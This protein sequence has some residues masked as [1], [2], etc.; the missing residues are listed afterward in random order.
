MKVTQ[1]PDRI[2]TIDHQKYLYFGGTSYLGLPN[3]KKFK[4]LLIKNILKWGTT[5]GSSRNANIQLTAYDDGEQFLANFI[6]SE[7][8]LTV[9]SGMLA[10]K[11]II[12]ILTPSTDCFFHFPN[13]HTALQAPNSL[14][15]FIEGKI[16][17]RLLNGTKE[18]ITILTDA[19]PS[20]LIKANDLSVLE[21]ISKTKIITLVLDESHSLGILGTHGCGIFSSIKYPTIQRKIMFSSLG[22]S[23]GLT[24]GV[25]ASDMDFIAQIRKN[26]S[27]VSSAGMNPAFVQ[28]IAEG[29]DIYKKQ[30]IKL[31]R[32]LAYVDSKLYF[33]K[34]SNFTPYYPVIYPKIPNLKTILSKEKII[35]THFAYPNLEGE[36]FRIVFTANHKKKDL[37]KII[38]I[39]NQ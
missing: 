1:C 14:A 11:I 36:L 21:M 9:S 8:A 3:H 6:Q 10:G 13:I 22:K 4:K 19:V 23:M 35:I 16:N 28:T 39:L 27:F 15:V 38:A 30:H 29:K 33:D 32:N 26:A 5:Y 20:S 12:E 34:K 24:G 7:A 17:P 18:Q 2:L 31:L 37:D 25:I